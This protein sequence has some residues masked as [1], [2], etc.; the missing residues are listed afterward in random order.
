MGLHSCMRCVALLCVCYMVLP[1]VCSL[2]DL[3]V[4]GVALGVRVHMVL[5]GCV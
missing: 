1:C 3:W 4:C 5:G 2:D